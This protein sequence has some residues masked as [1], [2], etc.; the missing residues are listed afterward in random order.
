MLR[1][2]SSLEQDLSDLLGA[3]AVAKDAE[4]ALTA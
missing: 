1:L 3:T 2:V 4:A